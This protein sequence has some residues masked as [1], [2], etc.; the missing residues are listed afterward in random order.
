MTEDDNRNFAR[1]YLTELFFI[2][3]QFLQLKQ[4]T[5]H[6]QGVP[7]RRFF[8]ARFTPESESDFN[9]AGTNKALPEGGKQ[10]NSKNDTDQDRVIIRRR[11]GYRTR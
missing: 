5:K 10:L 3:N 9:S 1:G 7:P 2:F 6:L 11:T 8:S 4:T